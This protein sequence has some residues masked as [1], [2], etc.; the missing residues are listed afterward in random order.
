MIQKRVQKNKHSQFFEE[1]FQ[2]RDQQVQWR[3]HPVKANFNFAQQFQ[4]D[5]SANVKRCGAYD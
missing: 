2:S 3:I 5:R 1:F 4:P